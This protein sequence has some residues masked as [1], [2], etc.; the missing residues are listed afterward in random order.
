LAQCGAQ[1]IPKAKVAY[2]NFVDTYKTLEKFAL[3]IPF[4]L[5]LGTFS[6]SSTGF[7]FMAK[8]KKL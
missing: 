1:K 5:F 2:L 3:P 7:K 6:H 4:L 8:E